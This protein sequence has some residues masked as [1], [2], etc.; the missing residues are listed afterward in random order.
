MLLLT[1]TFLARAYAQAHAGVN[2][3]TDRA[4]WRGL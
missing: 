4:T 1:S 3:L 2:S